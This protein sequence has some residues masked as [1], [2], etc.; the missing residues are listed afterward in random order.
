MPR[1]RM[2]SIAPLAARAATVPPWPSGLRNSASF[3][4]SSSLPVAASTA[5]I[6]PWQNT[7]QV[8]RRQA[9]AIVL[10]EERDLLVVRDR[11]GHHVDRH[12]RAVPPRGR[13]RLF[14]MNLQQRRARHRPDRIHALGM[15]EPEPAPLPSG[16][17]Q[18]A[19]LAGRE[20]FARRVA[21]LRLP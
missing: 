1:R 6:V 14:Q 5:G 3:S 16:V 10:V 20:R 9:E 13:Q 7:T 18:H 11:A 2:C 17:K 21:G 19:D 12:R 15:L 8:V 4:A